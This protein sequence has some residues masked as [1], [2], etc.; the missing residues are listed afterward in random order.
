MASKRR[1]VKMNNVVQMPIKGAMQA[2]KAVRSKMDTLLVT[3]AILES[4]ELPRFQRNLSESRKV[5]ALAEV[6]KG[7]GG[8]IPGVLTLGTL[9][10]NVKKLYVVDGQHRRRAAILSGLQE[11]IADV[12]IC[13]FDTMAEMSDEF[14]KLQ[15]SLVTM[16]PD[17]KLRAMEESS[18]AL[19]EIRKNCKII[20]YSY[21]RRAG[22]SEVLS[23]A[24]ALRS[25][26]AGARGVPGNTDSA[27]ELLAKFDDDEDISNAIK[28]FNTCAAAWGTDPSNYRMWSIL[29]MSI[30]SWMYRSLVMDKQRGVKRYV[31]LSNDQFK[32]CLMGV[33]ADA[34][35]SDW[36]VGRHLCERDRSPCYQRLRNI[37]I[38]RLREEA[39]S[40]KV[41]MPVPSWF[42]GGGS[43]RP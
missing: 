17:D 24:V 3:P 30:C 16:R 4:W 18:K 40:E 36:L 42:V 12:R 9:G 33:S 5:T 43:S 10:D 31:V 14:V 29:N 25:W 35:Y 41:F 22:R 11:F 15:L 32:K 20:G 13:M 34:D 26:V 8:F 27:V 28:F 37:F 6:I 2:P 39:G 21:L 23:A 38:K 19:R 1:L 7:N